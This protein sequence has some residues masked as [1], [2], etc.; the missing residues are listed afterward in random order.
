MLASRA[1]T[2][3]LEV[4]ATNAV[5]CMMLTSFP[6]FTVFN[7]GNYSSTYAISLPRYPHPTYTII[8]LFECFERAWEM[9][10]LPHPNAPGIA[11]VPPRIEGNMASSTL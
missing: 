2:G 3:M 8:S 7:A 9:Q 11:Q 5:L 6:F 4:L 10:V 1:A